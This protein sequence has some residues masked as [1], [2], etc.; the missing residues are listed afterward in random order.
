MAKYTTEDKLKAVKSVLDDGITICEA[1]RIHN[2]GRSDIR[3]WVRAYQAHGTA[4]IEK[5]YNRYSGEFKQ[6]VIQ[7]MH[8]NK[9]SLCKTAAKYNIGSHEVVASWERIFLDE[10]PEGLYVE[11]RGGANSKQK[12]PSPMLNKKQEEDLIAENK[13]L[14]MENDYLKKLNALV[15]EREKSEWKK[16][17]R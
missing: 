12:N 16:K 17:L 1:A 11:R 9:L 5:Q 10:G 15:Q 6:E 3:K 4:G 13:R 8:K 14:R 7:Y 2:V